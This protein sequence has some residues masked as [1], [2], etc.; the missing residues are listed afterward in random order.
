MISSNQIAIFTQPD[1]TY[2]ERAIE[3]TSSTH[4]PK[5][6]RDI[7]ECAKPCYIFSFVN[8]LILSM[9]RLDPP[10]IDT[11]TTE[12]ADIHTYLREKYEQSAVPYVF[13]SEPPSSSTQLLPSFFC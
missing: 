1:C 13:I 10:D 12:S 9:S 2:C 5:I 11:E 4:Y 6:Q 7:F 3:E 8:V